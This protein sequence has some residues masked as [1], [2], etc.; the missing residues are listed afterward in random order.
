MTTQLKD[1]IVQIEGINIHVM[2]KG[3]GEPLIY[4][5][6]S[7][8]NPAWTPFLESLSQHFDVIAPEHPGFGKSETAPWIRE[9]DDLVYFYRSLL[10]HY[11]IE[12][13]YFV[14]Q[15]FG[16]WITAEFASSQTH[17]VKKFVLIAAAG[18]YKEGA[19]RADLFA[20]S[21]EET[22]SRLVHSPEAQQRLKEL[23]SSPEALSLSI[24]NTQAFARFAWRI[25]YNVKLPTRLRWA[26]APALVLWGEFDRVISKEYADYYASLLPD[27]QAKIISNCGHLPYMEK[28]E[29]TANAVI[30]FCK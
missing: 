19:E 29:E 10:D 25:S 23:S 20:M 4:L 18:I 1:E 22:I 12:K 13:A 21:P 24:R 5:H 9:V 16:G 3:S 15:S 28:P 2:R 26:K 30:D 27:A 14:G 8:G 6:G 17:R 11:G 7:N